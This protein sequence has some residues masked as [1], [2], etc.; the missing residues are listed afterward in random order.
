M[1]PVRSYF[2]DKLQIIRPMCEVKEAQIKKI[3]FFCQ[4]PVISAKCL[5]AGK[6]QRMA[7]KQ[8]I[9]SMAHISKNARTNIYNAGFH[10]VKNKA[11]IK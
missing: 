2:D 4:L 8:I 11:E 3:Q 10:P 5:Y 1:R 7:M 6:N 9:R